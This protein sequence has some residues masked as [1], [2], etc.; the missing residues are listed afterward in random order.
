MV[1]YEFLI[2]LHY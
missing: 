1:K 2:L